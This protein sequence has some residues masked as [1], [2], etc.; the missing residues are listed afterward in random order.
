MEFEAFLNIYSRFSSLN[1]SHI[2]KEANDFKSINDCQT[3]SMSLVNELWL[4]PESCL[5]DPSVLALKI[6]LHIISSTCEKLDECMGI[7]T[8]HKKT[9]TSAWGQQKHSS[10]ISP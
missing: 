6:P 5:A 7:G 4:A 3:Q 8:M 9:D 1:L 10:I 2:N